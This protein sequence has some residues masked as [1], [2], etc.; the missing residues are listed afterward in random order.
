MMPDIVPL[1]MLDQS[2]LEIGDNYL[3]APVKLDKSHPYLKNNEL[4]G[5]FN[6]LNALFEYQLKHQKTAQRDKES[7]SKR[8][9]HD[10]GF[11]HFDSFKEAMGVYLNDPRQVLEYD[12]SDTLIEGGESSGK[13]LVWDV[14]GDFL[15]VGRFLEGEPE[16]MGSLTNGNPRNKRVNIVVNV[17]WIWSTDKEDINRRSS[18]IVRLVDWLESQSIR[19]SITAVASSQDSHFE[20]VAKQFDEPLDLNDLAVLAHSDFLRRVIFRFDEYS[21][22]WSSGYGHATIFRDAYNPKDWEPNYNEEYTVY[23]AGGRIEG[24]GDI[25]FQFNRLE[26]TLETMLA[27]DY[28]ENRVLRIL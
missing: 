12:E 15:D 11:F 22:T 17:D 14:Q 4:V 25:D 16:S 13:E 28:T 10:R 26:K 21:Q 23:V 19:T 1:S 18:R 3:V 9:S 7:N 27:E 8:S 6:G 5:K 24:G 2:K 20:L